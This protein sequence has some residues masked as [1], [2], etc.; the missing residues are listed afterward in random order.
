MRVLLLF[1]AGVLVGM[2]SYSSVYDLAGIGT[3]ISF[4]LNL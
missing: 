3:P 1:L 4:A 2:S